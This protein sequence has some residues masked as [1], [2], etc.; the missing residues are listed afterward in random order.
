MDSPT[1]VPEQ[2]SKV[3]DKESKSSDND[4][5]SDGKKCDNSSESMK[6]EGDSEKTKNEEQ[7]LST[8]KDNCIALDFRGRWTR[9]NSLCKGMTEALEGR[10]YDKEAAA[11]KANGPYVQDWSR[12]NPD[13]PL[14][15]TVTTFNT[16]IA[17]PYRDVT[18]T[19]GHFEEMYK[20]PSI[21]FGESDAKGS[22]LK[23]FMEYKKCSDGQFGVAL[24]VTTETPRGNEESKRYL[25][26]E[27]QLILE[28]KLYL[29]ETKEVI[30][31]LEVFEK[32]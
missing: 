17:T 11:K 6:G 7:N 12:N 5:K 24:V 15:W 27:G 14:E 32:S 29:D 1:D 9:E 10:G 3:S 16:E 30:S 28:R 21:L 8:W 4:D 22:I 2:K 26:K 13:D 19:V 25:S 23:R 20:G 18:Y 31:S